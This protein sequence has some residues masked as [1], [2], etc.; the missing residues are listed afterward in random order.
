MARAEQTEEEIL[1]MYEDYEATAGVVPSHEVAA[2]HGVSIATMYTRFRERGL[3]RSR[4]TGRCFVLRKPVPREKVLQMHEE[5]LAT[6]GVFTLEQVAAKHHVS[7]DT[8]YRLF[9]REN[10]LE[11]RGSNNH[12]KH[13]CPDGICPS[14]AKSNVSGEGLFFCAFCP[15]PVPDCTAGHDGDPY[16]E[17][18]CLTCTMRERCA[19]WNAELRSQYG[20]EPV[21][22]KW[23]AERKK[24][25]RLEARMRRAASK[26]VA[27]PG[28]QATV[29]HGRVRL[30]K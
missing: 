17:W 21:Y 2:N 20:W 30:G 29:R 9:E 1:Q 23:L 5:M 15:C 10:L 12:T 22:K 27:E 6:E 4:K 14:F 28:H 7:R 11:R 26:V 16:K 13:E 25:M 8:M 18:E 24:R 3:P 19:C